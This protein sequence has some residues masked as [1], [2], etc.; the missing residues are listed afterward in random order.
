MSFKLL[1]NN[2]P[3]IKVFYVTLLFDH[4][5]RLNLSVFTINMDF[6]FIML[7]K[8]YKCIFYIKFIFH[9]YSQAKYFHNVNKQCISSS[10]NFPNTFPFLC[11][12]LKFT[13]DDHFHR[14]YIYR[15]KI[16]SLN[17]SIENSFREKKIIIIIKNALFGLTFCRKKMKYNK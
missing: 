14:V 7:W 16:F 4:W 1:F 17:F 8:C 2:F 10:F 5:T 13:A 9:T 15:F 12:K 3:L 6:S 11:T